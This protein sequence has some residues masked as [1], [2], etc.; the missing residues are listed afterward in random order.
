[1]ERGLPELTSF[2]EHVRARGICASS[3][4]VDYARVTAGNIA[5]TRLFGPAQQLV[6]V[7]RLR[8]A[9]DEPIGLHTVYLPVEVAE[10]I[11]F[12]REALS[13]DRSLSLYE[14]L[15]QNGIRLVWAE[16]HLRARRALPH[17]AR[18]LGVH[19]GTAL[20]SVRRLT[21]DDRDQL[22][23][24]VRAVYLGNK[25]DYVVQLE[26]GATGSVPGGFILPAVSYQ[27]SA[28]SHERSP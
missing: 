5:E 23:E 6:E 18:L 19:R 7:V 12:T 10:R 26:R 20:M 21:R 3:I 16:E 24:I 15:G 9:N 25:Y 1:M 28:I 2:S 8:L 27:P 13:L 11:G 22:V 17:E 4:L 14:L